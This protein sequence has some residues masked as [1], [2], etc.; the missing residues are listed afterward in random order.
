MAESRFWECAPLSW[1]VGAGV[2]GGGLG[3]GRGFGV[4]EICGDMTHTHTHAPVHADS[5]VTKAIITTLSGVFD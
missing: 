4:M 3:P 2:W 5:N 1:I